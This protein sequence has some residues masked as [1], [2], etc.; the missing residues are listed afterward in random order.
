MTGTKG[1]V[2]VPF[3]CLDEDQEVELACGASFGAKDP[4]LL[5][6]NKEESTPPAAVGSG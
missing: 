2:P 4:P 3:M 1:A 6:R 5:P